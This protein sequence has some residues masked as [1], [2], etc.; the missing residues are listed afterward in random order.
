[1]Y[2]IVRLMSQ[3]SYGLAPMDWQY[4]GLQGPA[5]P[6]LIARSDSVEFTLRDYEIMDDF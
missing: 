5:P 1:M 4:G 3:P 6:V 2:L